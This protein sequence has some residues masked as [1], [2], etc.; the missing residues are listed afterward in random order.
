[1]NDILLFFLVPGL[2]I[3]AALLLH[4]GNKQSYKIVKE[5]NT[6]GESRYEVWFEYYTVHGLHGWQLEEKFDT[7]EQANQF[8]ATQHTIREIIREGKL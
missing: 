4:R 3:V 2:V 8:I 7:E 5:T 6:L 1:M